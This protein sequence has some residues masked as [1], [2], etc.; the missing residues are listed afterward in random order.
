MTT[1]RVLIEADP[2]TV[3]AKSSSIQRTLNVPFEEN[4]HAQKLG[5]KWN[6][7]ARFWYVP[8]QLDMRP[9]WRWTQH[10]QELRI[11][12]QEYSV[13]GAN[14]SCHRCSKQTA[15]Y[16]VFLPSG[17]VSRSPGA[18]QG[19]V[20][21]NTGALFSA[22]TDLEGQAAAEVKQ[23][24]PGYRPDSS[25]GKGHSYWMNHCAHCDTKVGDHYLHAKHGAPFEG[26]FQLGNSTVRTLVTRQEFIEFKADLSFSGETGFYD[27]LEELHDAPSSV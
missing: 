6:K 27:F 4:S 9:F 15:V 11:Q 7:V 16:S 10:G 20:R 13:V 2:A 24:A 18:A 14:I 12:H 8:P 22:I 19:W 5:A 3:T 21:S 25:V 1:I 23:L 26:R 17:F